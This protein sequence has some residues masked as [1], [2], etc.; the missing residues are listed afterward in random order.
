MQ[1]QEE[2]S[3]ATTQATGMMSAW[4]LGHRRYEKAGFY[5]GQSMQM[6]IKMDLHN[7]DELV[8]R[9]DFFGTYH[10]YGRRMCCLG[11]G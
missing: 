10:C 6:A 1:R 4:E 7:K 5:S 11:V 9:A 2:L 8:S 3:L